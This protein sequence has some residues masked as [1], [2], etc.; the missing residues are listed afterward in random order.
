[1]NPFGDE[2]SLGIDERESADEAGE[3]AKCRKPAG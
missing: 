2:R 3:S 1:L